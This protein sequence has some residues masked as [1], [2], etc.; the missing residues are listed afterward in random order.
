MNDPQETTTPPKPA[1]K[2]RKPQQKGPPVEGGSRGARKLAAA[3][4]EV[5]AGARLPSDAALALGI[6]VPPGR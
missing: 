4:L 3:I 2:K 1:N 6:G 5:L